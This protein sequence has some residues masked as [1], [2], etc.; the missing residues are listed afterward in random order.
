MNKNINFIGIPS[1]RKTN[2]KEKKTNPE[3]GSG[4]NKINVIG[5]IND[6]KR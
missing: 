4:C 2:K 6:K 3:P 1:L 5:K